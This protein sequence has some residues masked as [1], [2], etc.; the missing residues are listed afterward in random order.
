M[1]SING[2][3]RTEAPHKH[4]DLV[5]FYATFLPS[6]L[7][8]ITAV[9]SASRGYFALIYKYTTR[10]A[11]FSARLQIRRLG[12][13][14]WCAAVASVA[15]KLY[16]K[17]PVVYILDGW[18]PTL[19]EGFWLGWKDAQEHTHTHTKR[20][21]KPYPQNVGVKSQ[22]QRVRVFI[23]CGFYGHDPTLP[24]ITDLTRRFAADLRQIYRVSRN[25]IKLL[26]TN[27][28]S[29]RCRREFTDGL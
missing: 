9:A 21:L 24:R 14:T 8:A 20:S 28:W 16:K 3:F 5:Y 17:F 26:K 2:I 27:Y 19:C 13:A 10:A 23:S 11:T 12:V 15:V 6:V 22:H 18:W 29:L 25:A 4:S 7:S 1:P